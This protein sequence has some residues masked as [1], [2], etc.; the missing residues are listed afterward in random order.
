LSDAGLLADPEH[1]YAD[2]AEKLPLDG[3]HEKHKHENMD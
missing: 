3:K 1:G 2:S